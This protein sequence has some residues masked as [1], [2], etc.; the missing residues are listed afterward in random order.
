MEIFHGYLQETLSSLTIFLLLILGRV[1]MLKR[2]REKTTPMAMEILQ[3]LSVLCSLYL[4]CLQLLC[5]QYFF[6]SNFSST[7]GVTIVQIL[8]LVF[9]K[10]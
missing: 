9:A 6:I 3:K 1:M 2:A 10:H 7:H 5:L 4:P 8:T